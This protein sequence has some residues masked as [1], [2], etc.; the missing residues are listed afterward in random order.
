LISE[1]IARARKVQPLGKVIVSDNGMVANIALEQD[2]TIIIPSKTDLVQVGGE[3]LMPQAVVYSKNATVK[4]YIAW[5]GG[6][7][8]RANYSDIV[9]V[10]ANGL[11][12]FVDVSSSGQDKLVP[13]DQII[14]LPRV[15]AKTMQAIKDMTQIIFQIAVAA[16]AINN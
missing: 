1:F 7:S 12:E 16:N 11:T 4:D 14:V 15:E 3:V 10:H 5:A 13:G 8:N 9:V 6:Y 2:D